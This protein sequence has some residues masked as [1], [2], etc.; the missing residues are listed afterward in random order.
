MIDLARQHGG[1]PDDPNKRDPLDFVLWQPSAPDEPSWES[2]WGPGRPGWHIECSA[3]ALR[4]LDT[5]IDLHGGGSDL[6][7]PH[8][9]CEAAQSEAATGQPF[10][11]HWM[12]QA[13]VRMDGEKMSKSLGNLVFISEL[14]K[15]WDVRAIRLAIVSHHY[16]DSWEWD[17]EIMPIAAARFERWL[18]ATIAPG[19]VDS[20]AALDEVR[21]RLDDDLDTPGAVAAIDRAVERGEG[22]VSA[23][24]LLGV[25]LVGDP[26]R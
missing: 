22:V 3:L 9:E 10:V 20:Q 23:A 14:R 19:A 13:M 12:H 1:N 25:F 2:L 4:E 17:D 6:I 5:T 7:F 24:E 16:R 15:T 26:Q 21:V 8:H 11:R 18:A